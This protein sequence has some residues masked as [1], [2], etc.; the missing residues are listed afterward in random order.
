M[1]D[2]VKTAKFLVEKYSK[3]DHVFRIVIFKGLKV[4]KRVDFGLS[5]ILEKN[6]N[7]CFLKVKY[8]HQL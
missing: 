4:I 6:V 1:T 5:K 7:N 2:A 8:F 3:S